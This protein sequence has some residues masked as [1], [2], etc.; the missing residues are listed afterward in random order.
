MSK[1]LD[2]LMEIRQQK[3][4]YLKKLGVDPYAFTFDKTHTVAGSRDSLNKSV[5]TAG[6]ILGLRG[7]GALIF[8][9]LVDETGKI[10]LLF[11]VTGLPEL[12]RKIV[13]LLD[14]GD[15]IGVAGTVFTTNAGETTI[16]VKS[17]SLL[18]KAVRPL[19]SLWHGL[20]DI[21]E[22]YRQRYVDLLLNPEVRKVFDTRTKLLTFLRRFLDGQGF[23]EVE[24]PVLQPIYGGATARPFTTHHNTLDT[25]FYLRISNELYLKRLIVGGYDKVYEVSRDFRNEGIDRQ[26]NPEFTMIE[27]YWAYADYTDLMELTESM[28][29]AAVKEIVGATKLSYQG[30]DLDFSPPW[31]RVTFRQLLMDD[32]GIDIDVITDEASLLQVIKDKNL[33]LDLKGVTGYANILDVLYKAY[34]RP[35]LTGPVFVIDHPYEAMPLAKRKPGELSKVASVALIIAGFE[36]IKAYSELNDPADQRSRWLEEKAL[37]DKGAEAQM[38]DED[39]LRALEYGMPPTA[40]LGLGVDRLTTILTDQASLKDVIIFPTLKPE[41]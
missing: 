28:L 4:E 18:T 22:R 24:T 37:L 32:T 9:D 29:S 25:E 6:R 17:L 3:L 5:T 26:H 8:A 19:P 10:Q 16:E 7:H 33:K 30:K 27:F 14:I 38:L 36:I 15:I 20:S 11:K 12:D 40:G 13:E 31:P 2:Q 34:S 1:P 41:K 39:Y 23:V 35:K 21:E